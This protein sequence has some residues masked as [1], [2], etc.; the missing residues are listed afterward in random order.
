MKKPYLEKFSDVSDFAVWVVDGFYIRNNLNLEF[1]NF[2][3]HYRFPFVPKYEFWIDKEHLTHEEYFYINHMLTEWFLMDNGV[4]YDTAIGKADRKEL[5]ERKKTILMQ[6]VD[7]RKAQTSDKAVKEV[8][9]KRIDGYKDVVDVWMVNGEVVRGAYF[10][11]FTEGGHHF[12]YAFVPDKEVWIDGDLN[13]DEMPFVLLHELHE[14]FLMAQG[15]D[16][17]HAHASSSAI[18]Y[19]CRRAPELLN[20]NIKAELERNTAI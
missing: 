17:S 6:K 18:E 8:Y 12:V 13:P 2:G 15:M 3:Q 4:D 16:Y 1:T 14:R 19:K 7:G 10:I 5:A 20:E 11:D 9:V